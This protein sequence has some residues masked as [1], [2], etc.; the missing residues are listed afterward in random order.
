MLTELTIR[1][2]ISC[3]LLFTLPVAADDLIMRFQV[4]PVFGAVAAI[5]S[6]FGACFPILGIFKNSD[7][8]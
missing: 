8:D 7:L 5:A 4:P 6:F 2:G 3:L 1:I